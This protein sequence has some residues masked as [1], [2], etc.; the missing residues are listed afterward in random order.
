MIE[1]TPAI[2]K[3][4][5]LPCR[6]VEHFSSLLNGVN[7]EWFT[8][9]DP[10]G[11][12]LGSG[13]GTANLLFRAWQQAGSELSFGEWIARDRKLILHGGGQS[14]RLP[15][16]AP[17]SKL[18]IPVPVFRWSRG[19]RLDQTLMDLQLPE[20][21]RVLGHA[22]GDYP[23]MVTSGDVLLRFGKK[24]PEFPQVDVLGL[25][26]WVN[27]ELAK[28]FGVFFSHRTSPEEVQFFLQKPT[29]A[30]IRQ[31]NTEYLPFIDTGM[32]LLSPRA[33]DVLLQKCGWNAETQ[34]FENGE[35]TPYDL[36]AQFGASLG[37]Q[38]EKP[39]ELIAG[40]S[41]AVVP[42][43]EAEFY[44]LGASR[45]LIETAT[46]IQSLE[47]DESKIGLMGARQYPSQFLQNCRFEFP[48]HLDANHSLWIE[49]STVTAR[50]KLVS[51]H[52]L[53]GI[54]DNDW[55]LKLERGI[56][57][58][59]IP[60][61]KT[62][63]C[64]RVYHIDDTFQG[65]MGEAGTRW[66]N[67][68]VAE[69][70]S[71]RGIQLKDAGIEGGTDIQRAMLFPVIPDGAIDPRFLEWMFEQ[72]PAKEERFAKLWVEHRRLS[73]SG[74]TQTINLERYFAQQQ[75][76]RT[77]SLAPMLKNGRFSVFYKLDLAATAEIAVEGGFTTPPV[78][79]A[80]RARLEPMQ[81]VRD[82]MF[83]SAVARLRDEPKWEEHT[84][85]A[86]Q[87]M[88]ELIIKNIQ[89]TGVRPQ[90]SVYPD[91]IIWGR[92][93]VRLDL[94]GGWTDTPPYCLEHGGKVVN[95]AVDLN[96]QPPIQV[97]AR[98]SETPELVLRSIDLGME[99]RIRT[100]EE[101]D[102]FSRLDSP[103]PF[104]KAAF[105]L[106]GFLPG[107]VTQP[108]YRTL[109]EQLEDFG[110]GIELSMLAAVP[111]GSGLGTSSIL[112]TTLLAVLSDLCGLGWNLETLFIRT[113][114]L[115]QMCTTGGGWQDQ[116][117]GIYRGVKLVETNA[118][119][120]Q[121]P[122]LQWL[123]EHV[124]SDESRNQ[125]VLLYY[126]GV[127]RLAKNIL[128]EIV[129]SIFLNADGAMRILED[130]GANAQVAADAIQACDYQSLV[131][132][133]GR[134]WKLNQALDSGTNPP[135]IQAILDEVK[136]YVAA[137]KLLGA[138]GGGYLMMFAKDPEAGS[139]IKKHLTDNPPNAGAR[140]VDFAISQ[141]GLQRTRS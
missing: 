77:N 122:L 56:C 138:G 32:W 69:W 62:G 91:Q 19:Q 51:E 28:D 8:A 113:L 100:F 92:S 107:F 29:V 99:H 36:Y 16:Y 48:L 20:Y 130:I 97:F 120:L 7:P 55:D 76:N 124:F 61:G 74:L 128:D 93:P 2:Q 103:F 43:P 136:D 134:S 41:A 106:A 95:V 137:A 50:W 73:A 3:L 38:A 126:T 11:K 79:E 86:F 49:N 66:L 44:H 4:V 59:M 110:G 37:S 5:S 85:N 89:L 71:K 98:I 67:Q 84:R 87:V 25:G 31:L 101:L 108:G 40:L 105:A 125:A 70:F 123:P 22:A 119:L 23:V 104:A 82:E 34:E 1:H 6:I 65:N 39:D 116:A 127:T 117:G 10:P 15:A 133:V 17:I 47:P 115:E 102:T 63:M 54:P 26:M 72:N 13:G 57:L 24:L 121:R 9:S 18:L 12:P 140:F 53:T 46:R 75:Q 118:G 52:V 112:G 132:S 60:I 88:R 27:P 14:R 45:Q 80:I 30:R 64:V 83:R 135:A 94:A 21:E 68:P 141:T 35:P 139:R 109:R 90:K 58:D 33:V 42:L 114:A 78:D 81:I 96:G 111:K 131:Q 129:R